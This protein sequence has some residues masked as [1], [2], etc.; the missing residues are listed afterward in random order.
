MRWERKNYLSSAVETAYNLIG[1]VLVHET[2]EGIIKGKITECEAYGGFYQGKPDDGAHS[3]KGKTSRTQILLEEGGHAYIY[4]IYGMYLCMNIVCDIKGQPGGVLLRALEPV[5]G[6]DVMQKNRPKARGKLL[7]CGP[8]RL[9]MAMGIERSMYGMDLVSGNLYIESGNE[10]LIQVESS[11]RI[12]IEYA[13]Y[14]K[15]FPW[16]FTLKGS[17]WISK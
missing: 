12:N 2:S 8:G 11:K 1:A 17:S 3:F 13:T 6:I 10:Q 4:L 9:S 16:R 5:Q 14:G 7:T 15:H